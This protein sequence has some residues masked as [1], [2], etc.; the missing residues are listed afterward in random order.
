MVPSPASEDDTRRVPLAFTAHPP[1]EADH[2]VKTSECA[3]SIVTALPPS[4][5]A[6]LLMLSFPLSSMLMHRLSANVATFV[7]VAVSRR[8]SGLSG[9][10]ESVRSGLTNFWA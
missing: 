8:V 7:P 1:R 5:V 4:S 10:T 6:S 3:S 2:A 9:V